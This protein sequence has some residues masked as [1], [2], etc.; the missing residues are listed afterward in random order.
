[1]GRGCELGVGGCIL[2][3]IRGDEWSKGSGEDGRQWM[4]DTQRG[5]RIHYGSHFGSLKAIHCLLYW[6]GSQKTLSL[7]SHCKSVPMPNAVA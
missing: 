4:Q 5:M 6:P 7:V 1:M 3:L 2:R